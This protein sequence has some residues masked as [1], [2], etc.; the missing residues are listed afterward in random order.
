M[1]SSLAQ[2]AVRLDGYLD[3]I[4]SVDGGEREFFASAFI[5][6]NPGG[7]AG[8]FLVDYFGADAQLEIHSASE[9]IDWARYLER[10][11]SGLVLHKPFGWQERHAGTDLND[12]RRYISFR[13]MDMIA[14]ASEGYDI[15]FLQDIKAGAPG[16]CAQTRFFLMPVGAD[17]LVLQF[18]HEQKTG[19]E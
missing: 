10:A 8:D 9:I 6:N 15:P 12:R 4:A 19:P 2:M 17:Y 14:F 11:L 5:V 18:M 1:E 3:A 13:I 7:S 16:S